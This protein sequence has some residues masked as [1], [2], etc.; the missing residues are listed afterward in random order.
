MRHRTLSFLAAVLRGLRRRQ[1]VLVPLLVLLTVEILLRRSDIPEAQWYSRAQVIAARG[2]VDFLFVGTSKVAAALVEQCFDRDLQAVLH[3]PVVSINLGRGYSTPQQHYLGL[4]NLFQRY[5][6]SLHGVT[7]LLEC[8][9]DVPPYAFHENWRDAWINQDPQLLIPVLQTTDLPA[10]WRSD[11]EAGHKSAVTLR[12]FLSQSYLI[13]YRERLRRR[14]ESEGGR[15]LAR[16]GRPFFSNLPPEVQPPPRIRPM[17][18]IPT[19]PRTLPLVRTRARGYFESLRVTG[20]LELR[21]WDESILAEIVRMVQAHGGRVCFVNLPIYSEERDFYAT[22][23]HADN[24]T[25]F[26]IRARAWNTPVLTPAFAYTDAD[27]PDYF[28]LILARA[29][30]FTH[31]VSRAVIQAYHSR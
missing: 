18:G 26:Q 14:I 2:R 25:E 28:H 19:D 9:L 7:V 8:R 21:R 12:F 16:M 30:E 1:W 23:T 29:D 6:Q 5:P 10:F 11:S 13:T 24:K 20:P 31:A 15:W 4:R 17:G 27:V 22:E 3:R